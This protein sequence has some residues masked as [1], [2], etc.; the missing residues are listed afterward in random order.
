M[1]ELRRMA[2]GCAGV[3]GIAKEIEETARFGHGLSA[4]PD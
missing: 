2:G 4:A 1:V 3:D